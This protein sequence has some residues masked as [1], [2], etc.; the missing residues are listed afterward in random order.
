LDREESI[1]EEAVVPLGHGESVGRDGLQPDLQCSCGAGQLGCAFC[2]EVG[3]RV[4]VVVDADKRGVDRSPPV[5]V[6][7][8]IVEPGVE[9]AAVG[10][11]GA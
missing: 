9:S 1:R 6:D 4:V 2:R 10:F 11:V 3:Q 7:Q 8:E 5:V